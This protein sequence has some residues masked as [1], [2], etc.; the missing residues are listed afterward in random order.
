[1]YNSEEDVYRLNSLKRSR[2]PD[3]SKNL[4]IIKEVLHMSGNENIFEELKN[5]TLELNKMKDRI[6]RLKEDLNVLN[7][8]STNKKED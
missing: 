4:E 5:D 2:I 6:E 7:D 1:M 3:T 8:K